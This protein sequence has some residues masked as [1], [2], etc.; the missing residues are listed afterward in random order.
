MDRLP[1]HDAFFYGAASFLGGV[2]LWSV[3]TPFAHAGPRTLFLAG[4]VL[5]I[6]LI[7]R[8]TGIRH[9]GLIT[10]A[11]ICGVAYAAGYRAAQRSAIPSG[12]KTEIRGVVTEAEHRT[13]SQILTLGNG[14]RI[15]ADRYPEFSYGDLIAFEGIVRKPRSPLVTG[16]VNAYHAPIELIAKN[17]GN[18]VKAKLL[19]I[20]AAF[21][22]AL[23][24]ALPGEQA[25]FM[26][27]LTVGSTAGLS[28]EFQEDLR[29]SGTTHL[30]ALSGANVMG[31]I[32]VAL[33]ALSLVLPRRRTFWP[34]V[35]LITLFAVM[36]GAEPSL[37]RASAM[38]II[39]LW[40]E[41]IER[42]RN[43]RNAI[44]AAALAMVLWNPDLLAFDLGFQLSFMALLGIAYLKPHIEKRSPWKNEHFL[45][46]LAAQI[47][48]TPVLA[49]A[50]GRVTPWAIVPNVL[51]APIIPYAMGAGFVTGGAAL[52]HPSLAFAP[53]LSAR[54]CLAYAMAVI[55]IF[56]F[57]G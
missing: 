38:G 53:A 11:V 47:A 49:L 46:A 56:A 45:N 20:R 43:L 44:T 39:F 35:A 18:P 13:A 33:L 27:G 1:L 3:T 32:G 23:E 29:E 6:V 36:T 50:V 7:A 48:I 40:S 14:L 17:Q 19:E 55:H 42:T 54:V 2:A 8:E 34:L 24:S 12:T 15:T 37:V 41:R 26:A 21:E 10:C 31:L 52:V 22:R 5:A 57:G 4:A 28:P 9:I 16:T 51:L 25:A 30:V